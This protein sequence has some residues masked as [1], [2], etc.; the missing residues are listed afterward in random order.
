MTPQ[1]LSMLAAHH[2]G[3]V[4]QIHALTSGPGGAIA[5]GLCVIFLAVVGISKLFGGSR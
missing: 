3:I 5:F 4:H 2:G 1:Q